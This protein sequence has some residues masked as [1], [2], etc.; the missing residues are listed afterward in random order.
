MIRDLSAQRPTARCPNALFQALVVAV[1]LLSQL[2]LPRIAHGSKRLAKYDHTLTAQPVLSGHRLDGNI[3]FSGLRHNS[4]DSLY[5]TPSGAVP[6]NTEVKLR[7]RSFHNDVDKVILRL[8]D[9]NASAQR[10]VPMQVAAADVACLQADLASERCDFWESTI[11]STIANNFWYR[12]IINDG[13]SIAYYADNT[14]ALDGGLGSATPNP[15]DQ[16]FALMFHIPNL[17][18]PAWA[19]NQVIYQ[20]FPDRFNNANKN[21]DP[22]TG[23]LRYDNPVIALPWGTLP[24]GY[25]RNYSDAAT[26]CPA[27]FPP[28]PAAIEAP[29]GRDY[30]GGDLDGVIEKLEYLS[31]I[32]VTAIYFNPIF[33]AKS[34]H[35]YDTAD[36]KNID[37]TLGNN[38]TFQ[39]LAKEA[40]KLGIRIILD[41][42][43]NHMSSDS[44]NFDRY[45]HYAGTN[46]ACESTGSVWR[47][48]FVFRTPGS[49]E[50]VSCRPTSPSRN[51][52]YYEGWAGFDSIPVFKKD[53]AAL[54]SY[55]LSEPDSVT[56]FWLKNG[57]AGWRMDVMG[58]ASFPNGYW[59]TFYT[60]VRQT[61]PTALII[62]ELWQKDS[63]L[64]RYLRGDRADST[65]NY[66]LRDAVLGLLAPGPFDGKGFGDSGRIIAPS[67]F[68]ARLSSIQEDY[69][70]DVFYA[71][72]NLLDSHD[73]ERLLWTLTPGAANAKDKAAN[74]AI[75]KQRLRLASLIQFTLPGAPTI[76]YGDE[77]GVTGGDDPDDRRTYPWVKTGGQPD[78]KLLLHYAGLASLRRLV[79]ALTSGDL[80]MLLADDTRGVIAYGRKTTNQAALVVVNRNTLTQTVSVPVAGYLPN[81]LRLGLRW[82]LTTSLSNQ[83]ASF[84][85]N[86][87]ED[88]PNSI[89]AKSIEDTQRLT[90]SRNNDSTIVNGMVQVTVAPL[91][92]VLLSNTSNDL[93]GPNPPTALTVTAEGN[94]R[95]NL[96][97]TAVSDAIGYNLYRSPL[98]GGGWSKIT[99]IPVTATT[100]ADSGLNNAHTVYYIVTAMDAPGNEGSPSNE[101]VALPRLQITE[102]NL[103][104]L[105]SINHRVSAITRTQSIYGQAYIE[106]QTNKPGATA[107]LLVQLGYGPDGSN[108]AT[109]TAWTWVNATFNTDTGDNDE[110]RANLQPELPG[111]YDY[112]YRFSTNSGRDWV[113]AD[114]DGSSNGYDA[115]QAGTLN[116]A[117]SAD[118]TAPTIP[119]NI[120]V[121]SASPAG[122]DVAWN[123]ISGDATLFG[124]EVLRSTTT[125]DPYTQ[126]ARVTDSTHFIDRDVIEG[127]SYVYAVRAVDQS[128]NR[129]ATSA[130]VK[131]TAA[132]RTVTVTIN[133]T[134]TTT[135]PKDKK[136]YIAGF[137]DR[138]DGGL[139]QWNPGGVGLNQVKPTQ[140]RITLT[141]KEGTLIEYKYALGSWDFVEKDSA[142]G[143]IANRTLTLSYGS[144]GLQTVNDT[145]PNWRNVMP[146]GN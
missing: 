91:S 103:Q 128:F 137:V 143:E 42:V 15:V 83:A 22:K 121:L 118:T 78:T 8:Y 86:S 113:Y 80:K 111:S 106:G 17:T 105:P 102:A 77:V 44:P 47:G 141:G 1:V 35:R 140:W 26:H 33:T 126:I 92:G 71:L 28:N 136:V 32:G 125:G 61:D 24:E 36:Y 70:K 48:W 88:I 117:A 13:A 66:R 21:N 87:N 25:C 46:G 133:V 56:K 12:F 29:I 129:S 144:N 124:Y 76:Y 89:I 38:T 3:E 55:F 99:P 69:P 18:V 110:F 82:P 4:R 49:S 134:V 62:G 57:A 16:S 119:T 6:A 30:Y 85:N 79:P 96:A 43:F 75:G 108:P 31:L 146:C 27:R 142:C 130:N 127:T 98:S 52:T 72:M 34:N 135:T 39:K 120:R 14:P 116:V 97:W 139:P 114:H 93:I 23:D 94:A 84:D 7:L 53:S 19:R 11:S 50:P 74:D 132:L 37:P 58:D 104:R 112:A 131:A 123:A 10:L 100:F 81:G 20:I 63:T 138:L 115:A 64:L 109:G 73:T 60:Q 67:E 9:L 5:R 45:N 107:G 51:D 68:A 145:V 41:G 101:A 40:K 90:L 65:M 59:E 54:Q 122:I 95:I 2:S